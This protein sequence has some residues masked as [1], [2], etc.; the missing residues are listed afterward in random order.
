MNPVVNS[1]KSSVVAAFDFD[2][3]L[4]K[5][6]TLLPFL[7]MAVGRWSFWWG[8]VVMSPILAALALKLIPNWRAKEAVLSYFLSGKEQTKI[9]K[10]AQEFALEKIPNLLRPDAL[11]RL[12]WH[13]AQGHQIV[14]VSASLEAYLL[15]WAQKMGFDQVIGTQLEVEDNRL[16]GRI[17]GKNCYGPEKVARLGAVLGELNKYSIY[18]YGDSRGDKELLAVS[19]YPYYRKFPSVNNGDMGG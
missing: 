3:T 17:L 4:T 13:Q 2:G 15:P 6:D 1:S 9:Y 11:Q 19:N 16:T 18:A 5:R 10:I 7:L 14:L 8:L 12:Q